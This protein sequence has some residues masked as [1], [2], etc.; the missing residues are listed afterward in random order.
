MTDY[1]QSETRFQKNREFKQYSRFELECKLQSKE[2]KLLHSE[3][4]SR[5][6]N[7]V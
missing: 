7:S 6:A 5:A 1:K 3:K 2:W 4:I